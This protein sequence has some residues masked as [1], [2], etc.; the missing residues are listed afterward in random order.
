MSICCILTVHVIVLLLG[1]Q[2]QTTIDS[3]PALQQ[4]LTPDQISVLPTDHRYLP[5]TLTCDNNVY[6]MQSNPRGLCLIIN[7][8][9]FARHAD[10][11]QRDGS[12]ADALNLQKLFL[13]LRYTVTVLKNA[14][15]Q[16]LRTH[17]QAFASKPEHKAFDSVVICILSHGIPGKIYGVD[18][19]L[20]PITELTSAFNGQNAKDLV[21]KPKLF[22]IQACRGGGVDHGACTD[23]V[24]S[25]EVTI[26]STTEV[27]HDLY[28]GEDE[29]DF[30]S[31]PGM[32]PAEAD[33]LLAYSTVPG[34]VSWRNSEKGSWFVQALCEVIMTY[35]GQEDLVSMLVRVNG[36]VACEFASYD[37]KKQIPSPVVRL[38]K[39]VYFFPGY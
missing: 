37:Q 39:K 19:E 4:R 31:S 32:V 18:G 9:T 34:F 10:L 33:F 24:D 7:N 2:P 29:T 12:D 35:A 38:T 11:K 17:V 28:E 26:R 21:G 16:M 8:T 27:L 22:F 3:P 36:K 6:R 14:T 23:Q 20:V 30:G 13:C 1:N 15:A 5:K 25:G